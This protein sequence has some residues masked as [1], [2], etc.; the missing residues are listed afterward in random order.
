MGDNPKSAE[1]AREIALLCQ[2]I[3]ELAPQAGLYV[4]I[5]IEDAQ[6]ARN[7]PVSDQGEGE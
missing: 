4:G 2:R 1:A 3:F 6:V 7:T 5:K